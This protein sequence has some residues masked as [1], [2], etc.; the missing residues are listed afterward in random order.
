MISYRSLLIV[1]ASRVDVM[2]KAATRGADALIFDLEDSVAETARDKARTNLFDVLGN[3]GPPVFVRVNNP[4][5]GDTR[6]DLRAVHGP[7]VAGIVVPKTDGPRDVL[8]VEQLLTEAEESGDREPG[9]ISLLP[10]IESCLG[11]HNCYEIASSSPRIRGIM[12]A[13]AEEGD[14]IVDL[15]ARWSESAEALAYSRGRVVCESR[16]AGIEWLVDGAFMNITDTDAL[17]RE[18][19]LARNMGYCCKMAIHPA[20]IATI[21]DVF[22][23]SPE[24]IV[25]AE[26]IVAVMREAEAS[27]L[28]TVKDNGMMIDSANLKRAEALL[29]RYTAAINI[30][31]VGKSPL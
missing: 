12:L 26:R 24:E 15:D 23:P 5:Y 7:R 22:T 9:G 28:G 13:S 6:A 17:R 29:R 25:R 18:A 4:T 8:Q 19:I 2:F 10:T 16:A 30:T 11:V 21:N 27:G 3:A 14:L 20:Q 31:P 1:P